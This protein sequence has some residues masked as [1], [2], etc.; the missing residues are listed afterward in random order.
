MMYLE[1]GV[2]KVLFLHI[3]TVKNVQNRGIQWILGY[4]LSYYGLVVAETVIAVTIVVTVT[5]VDA[6]TTV[7]AAAITAIII[8]AIVAVAIVTMAVAAIVTAD[9]SSRVKK[10]IA[11][12]NPWICRMKHLAVRKTGFPARR[13]YRLR[14]DDKKAEISY[15]KMMK[16]QRLETDF[17]ASNT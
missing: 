16:R 2:S 13:P 10:A 14:S 17:A 12:V 3:L 7:V 11:A 1:T 8:A 4:G 15:Y 6:A 5:I 9:W